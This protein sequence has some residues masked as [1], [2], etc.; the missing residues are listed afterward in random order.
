VTDGELAKALGV[1]RP[2]AGKYR[3]RLTKLKLVDVEAKK[4]GRKR[5][6]SIETV[7]Y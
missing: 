5:E 3:E 2:T 7:K 4:T 1:S 6:F